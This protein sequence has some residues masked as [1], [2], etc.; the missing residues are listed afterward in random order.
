MKQIKHYDKGAKDLDAL[1]EGDTI[2][3]QP[4]RLG[5][6][7]WNKGDVN[8]QISDKSYEIEKAKGSFIRNRLHLKKTKEAHI[9]ERSELENKEQ[10]SETVS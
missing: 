10:R 7:S 1:Q 4:F 8:K 5:Q 2:C 9:V 6:K 3:V